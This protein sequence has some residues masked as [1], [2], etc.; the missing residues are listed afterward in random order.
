MH[1]T[2]SLLKWMISLHQQSMVHGHTVRCIV[3]SLN[4]TSY[5]EISTTERQKAERRAVIKQHAISVTTC[6]RPIARSLITP[7]TI[8]WVL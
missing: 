8:V 2:K 1:F 3:I 5:R 4:Q 7:H 6:S